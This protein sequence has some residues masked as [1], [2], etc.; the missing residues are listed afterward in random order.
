[1]RQLWKWKRFTSQRF[2]Q[3]HKIIERAHKLSLRDVLLFEYFW[4]VKNSKWRERQYLEEC[5]HSSSAELVINQGWL[6]LNYII[7]VKDPQIIKSVILC[8]W[9]ILKPV[10]L[11]SFKKWQNS[12]RNIHA[13]FT[14]SYLLLTFCSLTF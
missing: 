14:K 2:I 6:F 11:K 13:S 7:S 4:S 3:K 10:T 8:K 9:V 12:L 1:M 5:N